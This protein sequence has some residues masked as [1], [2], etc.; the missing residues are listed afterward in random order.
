[1]RAVNIVGYK[2]SGKSTLALALAAALEKLGQRVAIAKHSHHALDK[3]DTDS[4]RMR[5]QGRV[6]AALAADETAIFWGQARPLKELLPLF[7]PDAD[8]LLVEGGKTQYWLPRILCLKSADEADTLHPLHSLHS[9]H[10]GLALASYGTIAVP[11]LPHFDALSVENLAVMLIE[12]AFALPG[13]DCREGV[14]CA[15]AG[16]L[17]L[18]Q[19]LT[20][21]TASIEAC[22][23]LSGQ[24]CVTMNGQ[25]V[26]L[27]AFVA[28]ILGG[29]VRGM[30]RE[31]KGVQSGKAVITLEI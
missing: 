21:Q 12:R 1:M 9:L 29:A 10:Q 27:N 22:T 30:L 6:V 3:P 13:L 11:G 20:A 8:I 15:N 17:G 25:P 23:A 16:C 24:I 5:S 14:H 7:A 28:R 19:C 4:G 26:A 2:N 31:M 18:A